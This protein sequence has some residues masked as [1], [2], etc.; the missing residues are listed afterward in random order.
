MVI[1]K[2]LRKKN[3]ISQ[4]KLASLLNVHQT[5][6]SQ[7]ETDRT[8]MDLDTAK[9]VAKI[10]NVSVDYLLGCE[11]AEWS[12][13]EKSVSRAPDC[14]KLE[15][16]KVLRKRRGISQRDLAVALHVSPNTL[17]QW[18]RGKREPSFDSVSVIADYF[19]V[20]GDFLLG[21]DKSPCASDSK[22]ANIM[23]KLKEL[24]TKDA[25]SQTTFANILGVSRSTVAMW[26]TDKSQPDLDFV[27]K[28]ADYFGVT[29]DYL[30]GREDVSRSADKRSVLRVPVYGQVAAGIPI[31]AITDIDD[32]EELDADAYPAGDYIALRI[33]GHSM[34]PRMLE[35]DIVIVRLQDDVDSGD[36]AIVMVNGDE[37]T[38]KK[39]KKTPEG[40]M[41]ISTNTAYEPMFYT[42]K[43]V[44]ELPVRIIGKVVE[45]RAKY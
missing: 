23:L 31:E 20:S 6:I 1:L 27:V 17:N 5:A 32:Y 38:C 3:N 16:L 45:L 30:L 41:L 14:D 39:I 10:F 42:N 40:V 2:E 8:S 43:E 28:I 35:G 4:Q 15:R 24:R 19:D 21:R 25:I 9:K 44:T 29:V 12:T 37:A 7:W 13:A 22:N 26:E 18:E 33:H 36:I 11:N 34:E